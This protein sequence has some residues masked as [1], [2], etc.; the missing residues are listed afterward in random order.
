M[1]SQAAA[2]EWLKWLENTAP[3]VSLRESTWAYP[4]VETLHII[5]FTVLVGGAAMFDFRLLGFGRRIKV[6]D[7]ARHLLRWSRLSVLLVVPSGLLLFITQA[8]E[9]AASPV[10]RLKLS[11]LALAAINALAFQVWT[12]K[13]VAA[14]DEL[15][16]TPARAKSAA[17]LSLVL[18]AG[19]ISCGRFLAYY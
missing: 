13:N 1:P 14:W 3:A 4:V 17:L 2:G 7:L 12:L 8:T 18:W 15:V 5:G 16:A 19:I 6:T 9:M 11:L 10:F